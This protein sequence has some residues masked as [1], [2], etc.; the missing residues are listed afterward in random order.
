MTSQKPTASTWV[1]LTIALLLWA[2]AFPGIRAGLAAAGEKIGPGGFGPGE[3]AL[4]RFGTASLALVIYATIRRLRLPDVRDMPRIAL[5]GFLGITVYHVALNVGERTVESGAAALLIALSPVVTALLST[6]FLGERLSVWGW[7]GILVSFLGGALVA[8]GEGEGGVGLDTGALFILVATVSTSVYFILGKQ[9]LRKYSA[10]EFTSYAIWAGTVPLLAF[11]PSLLSQLGAAPQSSTVA[12]IYLGIFPGAIAYV[13]W[14]AGL[15][16]MPASRVSAF[17]YLQPVNAA[18][19]AWVWL[20]E[21]PG[22][23]VVIGGVVSIIGVVLVN[24]LGHVRGG[25]ETMTEEPSTLGEGPPPLT[26]ERVDADRPD[27]L[28]AARELLV[29]Y[30]AWLSARIESP[31][32]G[33]EIATLADS[34][35]AEGRHLLLAREAGDEPVGVI[36]IMPSTERGACEL[37]RLYVRPKARRTGVARRLVEEAMRCARWS[38]YERAIMTTLPAAMPEAGRLYESLGFIERD[39]YGHRKA[40]PGWR[41]LTRSTAE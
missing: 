23:W 20:S 18:V 40:E 31:R 10:L 15:A 21:V 39:E 1:A 37:K 29:E 17:L 26:I 8:L 35:L 12:G 36:G 25:T 14:S 30:H 13:L 3:L 6:R 11:A 5:A 7:L 38:G 33:A 34:Y 19:I 41:Y 4:L 32:L 16:S 22:V 9:P 24:T 27:S 2:S 28:A